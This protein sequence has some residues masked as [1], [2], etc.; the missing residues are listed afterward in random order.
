MSRSI[1]IPSRR[2]HAWDLLRQAA[3]IEVH[4]QGQGPGFAS[5]ASVRGFSSDHSTDLALWIDGVPINEPSNG[6][7]EGYSDWSLLFPQVVSDVDIT[8]GPTNV[9]FGNFNLSGAVNVPTLERL[10]GSRA[11]LQGGSFGLAD[12]TVLT[13][14]DHGA[15]GGGVVG[16]RAM[17]QDG[18]RPNSGNNLEQFHARVTRDL[19]RST[20]IDGGVELYDAKWRS[21]GFLSEDQFTGGEY[22]IASNTSDQGHRQRAQERVS[23]R[24][25]AG[26]AL[27]RTTAY[28][29]QSQWQLF[30]TIPPAGGRFEG[31]GSQAEKEDHRHGFGLTSAATWD[32]PY[33]EITFGGETRWDRARYENHFTTTRRRDSTAAALDARQLSGGVFPSYDA[34]VGK[35]IHLSLG[36]RA[37]ALSTTSLP[38]GAAAVKKSHAI[39]SPKLGALAR[40][41]DA[42]SAFGNFTRGSSSGGKSRRQGLELD[43]SLPLS[44]PI[45]THGSWSLNDAIYTAS[46]VEGEDGAPPVNLTGLRVCNTA[47]Y[48][49]AAEL[50][51]SG[52]RYRCLARAGGTWLGS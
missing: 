29:T 6:H 31:S 20:R 4:L 46:A 51:W 19:S 48:V 13:G 42:M 5:N 40:V 15:S 43:W 49:G 25:I 8:R 22:N 23:L 50:V 14:F 39:V 2:A 27:W 11:V 45:S 47:R 32:I 18:F 16:V 12:A 44:R 7:A 33:G 9:L 52:A 36:V 3:G 41:T 35:R 38:D 17:R 28:A 10:S 37:D 24:V 1:A 21:P 34:P 26:S 30:L